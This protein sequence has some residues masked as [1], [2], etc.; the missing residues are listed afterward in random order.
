MEQIF[1]RE[2]SVEEYIARFRNAEVFMEACRECPNFGR[3]WA[4]P[5]FDFD[6]LERI[7]RYTTLHLVACTA[8]LSPDDDFTS[9]DTILP[10]RKKMDE[11]LLALESSYGSALACA[12]GG[13]CR[14]CAACARPE[15]LPCRHPQLVRPALEAYGFDVCRTLD[16]LFGI[17][18]Q[19]AA[20]GHT[21]TR[22]TLLGGVF[23]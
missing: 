2:I 22:L 13:Y 20:P 7:G 17:K 4:C 9:F 14:R 8:E 3:T 12:F 23:R 1:E 10:L 18:L 11:R 21:P 15:G 19:W 6:V 16:E 5:P